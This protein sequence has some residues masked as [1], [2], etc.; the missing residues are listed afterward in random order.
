[1]TCKYLSD[2]YDERCVNA[3]CPYCT[4]W[5]PVTEHPEVC[6]FSSINEQKKPYADKPAEWFD[7]PLWPSWDI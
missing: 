7:R 3:D 4:D 1:M 5:C 6:R 2:D